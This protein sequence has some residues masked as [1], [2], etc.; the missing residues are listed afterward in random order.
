MSDVFRS[1]W[2]VL[3]SDSFHIQYTEDAEHRSSRR[4]GFAAL[5]RALTLSM[6]CGE[7]RGHLR[8][9]LDAHPIAPSTDL[10]VYVVDLHNAV[11]RRQGK[12][13]VAFETARD[14]YLHGNALAL[15]PALGRC[16]LPAMQPVHVSIVVG[17][18]ALIVVVILVC[19]YAQRRRS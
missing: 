16:T 18:V 1:L 5:L 8:D 4:R 7:C 12:R 14:H 11:N 3:H 13:E 19:A 2:H 9:H 6:R 17:C 15:C 10:A